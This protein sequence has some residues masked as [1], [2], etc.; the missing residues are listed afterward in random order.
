MPFGLRNAAQSFQHFIDDILHG[1]DFRSQEEHL[2]RLCL[3]LQRLADDCLT[4]DQNKCIFGAKSVDFLGH[5]ISTAGIKPLEDNVH[6][7]R[8]FPKPSFQFLPLRFL[9]LV[10]FYSSFIPLLV[11]PLCGLFISFS[12][13]KTSMI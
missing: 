2:H 10:N 13:P 1:L 9:G 7:I 8:T 4:I 11:P 3:V 12:I 6:V 5:H